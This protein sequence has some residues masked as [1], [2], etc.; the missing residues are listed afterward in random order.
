[1]HSGRL[2]RRRSVSKPQRKH[3]KKANADIGVLIDAVEQQKTSFQWQKDGGRY[4][5]NPATWLNQGRWEDELITQQRRK[6]FAE[7]AA[8]M[9]AQSDA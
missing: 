1:M 6:S 3:L 8:E 9:E 5:P 2:T 7:L 4:I